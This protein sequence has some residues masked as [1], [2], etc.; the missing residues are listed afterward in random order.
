MAN[1]VDS[2]QT[3][4]NALNIRISVKYEPAP[5]QT[6]NTYKTFATSEDSVR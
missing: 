5:D 3:W 4:Q 6:Y 1:S 2:D